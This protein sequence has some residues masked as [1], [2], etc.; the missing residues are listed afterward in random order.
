MG[1]TGCNHRIFLGG[2]ELILKHLKK[3]NIFIALGI[4]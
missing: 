2:G 4:L 3:P 1:L